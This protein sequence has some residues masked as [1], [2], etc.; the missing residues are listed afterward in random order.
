MS[1]MGYKW[2]QCGPLLVYIVLNAIPY[3][4]TMILLLFSKSIFPTTTGASV[5]SDDAEKGNNNDVAVK[6]GG[7]IATTII[8][9][10]TSLLLNF[11]CKKRLRGV[12]WFI[13]IIP[14]IFGLIGLIVLGAAAGFAVSMFGSLLGN[15]TTNGNTNTYSVEYTDTGNVD[16]P[17]ETSAP[18]VTTTSILTTA[19]P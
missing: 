12:A 7:F 2:T 10:V 15:A 8:F 5:N 16:Q 9:I 17:I 19:G 1:V 3:V 14:F 13:V 11:L 4:L 6:V 18:R